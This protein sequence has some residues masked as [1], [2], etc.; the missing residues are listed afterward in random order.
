MRIL[1]AYSDSDGR[2]ELR[3]MVGALF[4]EVLWGEST[5]LD[6]AVG[7]CRARWDAVVLDAD[8]ASAA[9]LADAI[10]R[11]ADRVPQTPIIVVA[12]HPTPDQAAAAA[13]AG[14]AA[15]LYAGGT[16][17]LVQLIRDAAAG[18]VPAGARSGAASMIARRRASRTGTGSKVLAS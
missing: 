7:L 5:T 11:L 6:Q 3:S 2:R 18:R 4:S 13:G 15:Y 9:G 14:A 1:L 16:E 10:G 12:R 17:T 8:L